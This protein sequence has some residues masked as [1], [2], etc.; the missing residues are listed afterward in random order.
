MRHDCA[1]KRLCCL[2][3]L[4]QAMYDTQLQVS[5]EERLQRAREAAL[6]RSM[7]Q[8]AGVT[9]GAEVAAAYMRKYT[10]PAVGSTG[11][12]AP[13]VVAPALRHDERAGPLL[14]LRGGAAPSLRTS[15]STPALPHPLPRHLTSA[16]TTESA[17]VR[18]A[19]PSTLAPPRH[20]DAG[21]VAAAVAPI[22]WS[23]DVDDATL[24]RHLGLTSAA[25][26]PSGDHRAASAADGWHARVHVAASATG[27]DLALTPAAGGVVTDTTSATTAATVGSQ[28]VGLAEALMETSAAGLTAQ[29]EIYDAAVTRL[30]ETALQAFQQ[31]LAELVALAT[32][33]VAWLKRRFEH[34]IGEARVAVTAQIRC[35]LTAARENVRTRLGHMQR[36]HD[37]EMERLQ[38]ESQDRECTALNAYARAVRGM[39]ALK[40]ANDSLRQCILAIGVDIGRSASASALLLPHPVTVDVARGIVAP[41]SKQAGTA[42]NGP[43]SA[44][45]QADA[46]SDVLTLMSSSPSVSSA[47][48]ADVSA[49]DG[50]WSTDAGT[51]T[52]APARGRRAT[53]GPVPR[54]RGSSGSR[55][56]SAGATVRLSGQT[57]SSSGP[58]EPEPPSVNSRVITATRLADA[59]EASPKIAAIVERIQEL[60]KVSHTCTIGAWGL[61]CT[62]LPPTRSSCCLMTMQVERYA[63]ELRERLAVAES[64]ADTWEAH[65]R[66][67]RQLLIVKEQG[68]RDGVVSCEGGTARPH[69]AAVQHDTVP[70]CDAATGC[71][72][73]KSSGLQ[74]P[75]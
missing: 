3:S 45:A 58:S 24:L 73:G 60:R 20:V 56:S 25:A 67:A 30:A 71:A 26:K 37:A 9:G 28:L 41:A 22:D 5:R 43:D 11:S 23:T 68:L 29:R 33:H 53:L 50:G 65:A 21:R 10:M 35:S 54:H 38:Q 72:G 46:A 15:M 36:H 4:L 59:D 8:L 55:S 61:T 66:E 12:L 51:P 47:G 34:D 44:S 40:Q 6:A 13:V 18:S 75:S 42:A 17:A 52:A 49:H 27:G 7:A 62:L 74:A 2:R 69:C 39:R 19:S 31:G 63:A 48:S 57:R 14:P 32:D 70:M 64:R 1:Y 16:S